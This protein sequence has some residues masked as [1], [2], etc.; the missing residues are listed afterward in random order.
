MP[1][2][3]GHGLAAIAAGWIVARPADTSRARWTQG[4]ILAATGAAPDLDLLIGQHSGAVHSIGAAAIVASAAAALRW[5]VARS[6]ALIWWSVCA[7]WASHPLLDA[8]G[9]DSSAPIGVMALWPFTSRYFHS[10]LDIFSSIYRNWRAPGIITHNAAAI[11]REL[12]ILVPIVVVI[13]MVR[14]RRRHAGYE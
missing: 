11:A 3:V 6:R 12:A 9:E 8:L 2:P 1:S 7:A 14:R 13:W 4:A 5:P 10:G